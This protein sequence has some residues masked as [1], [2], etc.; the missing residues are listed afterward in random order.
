MKKLLTS[1]IFLILLSCSDDKATNE[2]VPEY[3]YYCDDINDIPDGLY[4]TYVRIV[5]V[6]PNPDGD[7]DY[8]EKFRI[9]SYDTQIKFIDDFYIKDDEGVRWDL[10]KL[11]KDSIVNPNDKECITYEYTSDKVAQLLN[12][13]DK[14]YLYKDELLYQTVTYGQTKSGEWV[15]VE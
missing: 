15:V 11:I 7:D 9:K 5:A 12:T 2:P 13:G 10:D 6:L 14:I 3:E 4:N 1:L 8:A